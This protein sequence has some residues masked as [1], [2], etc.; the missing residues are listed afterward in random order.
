MTPQHLEF[1]DREIMNAVSD[2]KELN[3]GKQLETCSVDAVMI[4]LFNLLQKQRGRVTAARRI[5][6][7]LKVLWNIYIFLIAFDIDGG[8]QV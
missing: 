7:G 3:L 6:M 5:H 2:R 8:V 1:L 4:L